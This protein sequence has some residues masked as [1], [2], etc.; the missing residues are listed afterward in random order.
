MAGP[1]PGVDPWLES[2]DLWPNFHSLMIT[3]MALDLNQSLPPE[4][5]A[6]TNE[7]LYI[8]EADRIIVPDGAIQRDTIPQNQQRSRSA[9]LDIDEP[10]TLTIPSYTAREG[11]IEILA[12]GNPSHVVTVIELLSPT[13]KTPGARGQREYLTKQD[14]VLNENLNLLEIDL[15]RGGAHT[16]AAPYASLAERGAWDYL[17]CLC[18]EGR[19][20]EYQ[21]WPVQLRNPLP[22]ILVPLSDERDDVS[23]NIQ[24]LCDQAYVGGR[25]WNLIH[26]DTEPPAPL[27]PQDRAWANDLL[28]KHGLPR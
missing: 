2:R 3:M 6:V 19:R 13:N 9:V 18:R 24:S 10:E 23:L 25:F 17:I 4:Y 5:A 14:Q 21:Y 28:R 27:S 1:F 7:R 8:M 16:V 22:R 20:S 12:V 26:Y 11:F 15:L